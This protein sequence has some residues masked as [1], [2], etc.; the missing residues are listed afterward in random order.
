MLVRELGS[1]RA[2][3]VGQA[4]HA[5]L[6]GQLAQAWA[7][8]VDAPEVLRLTAVQHD[9]GMSQ[10]D[11]EPDLDDET[12][13]PVA[14]TAMDLATHAQLWTDA[15]GRLVSQS[16]HAALLVSHHG[17]RLYER[18]PSSPIV[19][20]YLAGQR[21]LQ[22]RW[23]AQL[24]LEAA[25]VERQAQLLF[26]WDALSLALILEWDPYELPPVPGP[27][28][29]DVVITRRGRTLDPW[30]LIGD[31]LQLQCEVRHLDAPA[32]T[33]EALRDALADAA[34]LTLRI[35]LTRP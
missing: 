17:T 14:F 3:C 27:D 7:W 34:P 32:P 23:T 9:V 13:H 15:P 19:D 16:Q 18:R 22:Q 24:G 1:G 21:A 25:D 20:A 28:G 8:P 11:V 33:R 6:A 2:L 35:T 31:E 4:S 5:W 12:G 26:A 29:R 10:W 30:P